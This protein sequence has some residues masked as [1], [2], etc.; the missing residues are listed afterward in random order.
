MDL[1][2]IKEKAKW[3]GL[4]FSVIFLGISSYMRWKYVFES[5]NTG[6][7]FW[8][9]SLIII[10][11]TLVCGV[12]ALPRWQSFVALAVVIYSVYWL[13]GPLYAVS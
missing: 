10:L 7:M 2:Q 9:A 1:K 8:L 3:W 6:G 5:A 13:S 11:M 12:L 4:I